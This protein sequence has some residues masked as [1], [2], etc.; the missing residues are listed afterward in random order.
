MWRVSLCM[1]LTLALAVVWSKAE[2]ADWYTGQP[3]DG[4]V[5]KAPS[6]AIDVA[7]DGTSQRALAA[8]MIGTIAPF[9]PLDTSGMRIRIAGL[10]GTY[11]YISSAPGLGRVYGTLAD[12][13]FMAGYE[14]VMKK[15]TVAIFGGPEISANRLS[16]YDPSNSVKGTRFGFRMGVDFYVQPTDATMLSGVAYYSTN[17]DAYYGRLK[18]GFAFAEHLYIGPEII[19][20]GDN[21]FQQWRFGGHLSGLQLGLLQLGFSGGFLNDR[22]RGAGMYGILETRFTF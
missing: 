6:V 8:A 10:G 22:V 4:P 19:A 13:S 15:A 7:I 20:L 5:S 1:A 12:G 18:F 11:N 2:A 16:E 17:N 3:N 21:Y 14:W 9:A